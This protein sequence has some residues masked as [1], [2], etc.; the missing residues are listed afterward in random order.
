M[1]TTVKFLAVLFFVAGMT[2]VISSAIAQ[3]TTDPTPSFEVAQTGG[4][5][6]GIC[7]D[8]DCKNMED[9]VG[10]STGQCN[11]TWNSAVTVN[12]AVVE[13]NESI[14]VTLFA[15]DVSGVEKV[16]ANMKNESGENV[17]SVQLYDD[18]SHGDGANND[19]M[20]GGTWNVGNSEDG[21][22]NLSI[23]M[24]DRLE[25]ES[26]QEQG[27]FSIGD[28]PCTQD[29]D[30][31]IGQVCCTGSGLCGINTCAVDADCD[32]DNPGTTDMC[33]T[34]ACPSYCSNTAI[35]ECDDGSDGFCPSICTN[36]P[37]TNCF[38][39]TPPTVSFIDPPTNE[40]EITTDTY[41]VLVDAI[42]NES[43]VA[44]VVFILDGTAMETQIEVGGD[45]YYHWIWDLSGVPNSPPSYTLEARATNGV[46]IDGLASRTVVVNRP[47]SNEAPTAAIT[48]P[49]DG[50]TVSGTINVTVDAT[51]DTAVIEVR[52]FHANAGLL[53][54]ASA[55]TPS[56]TA[57]FG[58]NADN[59]ATAYVESGIASYAFE[60][61]KSIFPFIPV[62]HAAVGDGCTTT[63][64]TTNYNQE[65]YAR[66]YDA[67]SLWGESTHVTVTTP[68]TTTSTTC[69]EPEV[70]AP[71]SGS[72]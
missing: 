47:V 11:S 27:A 23:Y 22:Y 51:D 53:G 2:L 36:P 64:T 42:D 24:Q 32:D 69:T 46:G 54:T 6:I 71:A 34:S 31:D 4:P 43:D 7:A 20:Y 68:I 35:T 17:G 63:T 49:A 41:E 18:G 62:A 38:D 13:R 65:I 56:I 55:S 40:Y 70:P 28:P 37:D 16:I 29:T 5:Q 15:S 3:V 39:T 48:S 9:C 19:G 1:K 33:M 59:T 10:V 14:Q 61:K 72:M 21:T 30:C 25:N 58:W 12:P 26:T 66:A 67:D 52:L 8:S 50:A 60:P 44:G 57:T 45:G